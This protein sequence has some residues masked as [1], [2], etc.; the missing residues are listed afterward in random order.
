MIGI[1]RTKPPGFL[2]GGKKEEEVPSPNMEKGKEDAIPKDKTPKEE[3]PGK[4]KKSSLLSPER[5][6]FHDQGESCSS[7]SNFTSSDDGGGE[8]SKVDVNF[9][10]SE[11]ESSWCS[12]FD[13]MGEMMEEEEEEM[14]EAE[15]P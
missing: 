7:C 1:G 10:S 4:G 11:P 15:A 14:E 2:K 9:T 8:C 3:K 12:R 6:G 5:A 13:G